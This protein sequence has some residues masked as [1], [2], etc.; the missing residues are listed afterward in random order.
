MTT[1]LLTALIPALLAQVLADY[2]NQGD[3]SG[4]GATYTNYNTYYPD[5]ENYPQSYSQSTKRVFN[6]DYTA[7]TV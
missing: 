1:Q 6:D 4:Q 3:S 2:H 5:Y 7:S